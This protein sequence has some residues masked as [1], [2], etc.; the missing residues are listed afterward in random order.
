MPVAVSGSLEV[1]D[2]LL[3]FRAVRASGP[4]GQNV[5]KVSNAIELRFDSSAWPALQPAARLR[6]ARLAGRRMT[7]TGLIV[8]DAQRHRSL[9]QNRADAIERLVTMVRAALVE[10]KPRR[11]TRP[12][13]AAKERRLQGKARSSKTKQLRSRI[14]AD[15]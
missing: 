11:P 14:R 4:G 5:N 2:E 15:D 7:D 6:L 12:T 10:P 1:P 3:E 9:E 13:R 8:I